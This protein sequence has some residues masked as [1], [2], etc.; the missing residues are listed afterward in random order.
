MIAGHYLFETVR[1][2]PSRAVPWVVRAGPVSVGVESRNSRWWAVE[3]GAAHDLALTR[4]KD[5]LR[6]LPAGGIDEQLQL[7]ADLYQD[8]DSGVV[9]EPGDRVVDC[10]AFLGE[11][12]LAVRERAS[13]IVS[14]EPDPRSY[15][16]LSATIADDDTIHARQ[17]AAWRS[18]DDP[19]QMMLGTDPSETSALK[20]DDGRVV[21][22]V[23]AETV[24]LNDIDA[25]FAKIEAEGA[26]PEV[27]Q[28]LQ[29]PAIPK[30]AVNCDHERDGESPRDAVVDHLEEIGYE[31]LVVSEDGRAV[32]ANAS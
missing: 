26:E 25:D 29:S 24:T 22:A 32:Y 2:L 27:L 7:K 6:L 1:R 16:A 23:D 19:L 21:G 10:G 14:L 3:P 30:V 20:V 18:D 31:T 4:P 5:A 9:V 11:F 15:G 13:E 17:Q 8:D 28:G 12:A